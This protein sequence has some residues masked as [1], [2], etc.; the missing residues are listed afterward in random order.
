M[1]RDEAQ[2]ELIRLIDENNRKCDEAIAKA[3]ANG[4]L[5]PGFDSNKDIFVEID[6]ETKAKIKELQSMIDE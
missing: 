4:T 1:T 6:R 3:K 5:K 2:K